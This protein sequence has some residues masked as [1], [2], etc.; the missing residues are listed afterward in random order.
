[1]ASVE[2]TVDDQ[3]QLDYTYCTYM[4][5]RSKRES[6]LE[7]RQLVSSMSYDTE[8]KKKRLR[9]SYVCDAVAKKNILRTNRTGFPKYW[10][11]IEHSI[12]INKKKINFRKNYAFYV[13]FENIHR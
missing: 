10:S 12:S 6:Q 4:Y 13:L 5:R 8:R 3:G 1:M 9:Y 7:Y 11:N 2:I